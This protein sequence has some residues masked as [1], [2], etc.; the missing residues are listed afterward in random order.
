MSSRRGVTLGVA[1][2]GVGYAVWLL[3]GGAADPSLRV[4]G[5]AGLVGFSLFAAVC[6][7]L[8][9]YRRSG[10]ERSAWAC[11]ALGT[12]GW[13]VGAAGWSVF[14]LAAHQTPLPWWSSVGYLLFLA[15]AGV[16]LVFLLTARSPGARLR[17][18]LDGLTVAAALFGVAWVAVLDDVYRVRSSDSMSTAWSLVYP[19][20]D[21]VFVAVAVLLLVRAPAHRRPELSLLAGGL[22]LIA[23]SDTA[24]AY[25]AATREVWG[26]QETA[27]GWVLGFVAIG[28]GALSMPGADRGEADGDHLVPSRTSTWLPYATVAAATVLCAPALIDGMEPVF[29]GA[30]VAVFAVMVRQ[31]LV[32][33]ENRR[34]LL[35]VADQARGERTAGPANGADPAAGPEPAANPDADDVP[36][37]ARLLG[38]LRHAIDH[39]E[40]TMFYQPKVDIRGA[41]IVGMEALIRWPHPRR[42]LLEPDRFLPL[43]RQ[44]GLMRS[45]TTVVLEL[46]LDEAAEWYRR[47]VGVPVAV[48]VFAPAVSDPTLPDQI[49]GALQARGLSPQALTVEITEDLLL[50]DMDRTRS[51]LNTLRSNGIRVAIDDFGSGYSA[52]WYLREFPVDEIKLDKEFIA[53]VLTQPTSAEIVRSVVNLAHA[54]GITPVAEGVENAATAERLRE[55]GCDVGQGYLYSRPL[56]AADTVALLSAHKRGRYVCD[57][58]SRSEIELM[59]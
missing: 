57:G 16:C 38:E 40:L 52:L 5:E 22:V 53:P 14:R 20:G 15:G 47:G 56:P 17:L 7:A 39:G 4:A 30:A 44:H 41:A 33:G 24:Y 21:I 3:F 58:T 48:N 43:V 11:M 45:M 31:F 36:D 6:S 8:A 29:V 34:L 35:E 18:M 12:A 49:M 25:F 19:V 37:A 9:A 51:V 46:A 59:Q 23:A 1:V 55:F 32:I 42:G 27:V 10:R 26:P 54:L 50:A 28:L 2:A 13:A